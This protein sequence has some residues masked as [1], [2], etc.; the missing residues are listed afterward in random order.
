MTD[1][2]PYSAA[3]HHPLAPFVLD[4]SLVRLEPLSLDH[5]DGLAGAAGRDR[6][7][8]D[9]TP[10]PDGVAA[11]RAYV[12]GLLDEQHRGVSLPF[13]Q[14]QLA[15]GEVVGS[16]RLFDMHWWR[17]R[18]HPDE[19]EIGGTWLARSAQRTGLNRDAK[20]LLLTHAFEVWGVG[21]VQLCTDARNDRSR[22]AIVGIGASFEGILRNHRLRSD[23]PILRDTAVYSITDQEWPDV[24]ILL[25][26]EP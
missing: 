4:G 19:V 26:G 16:T 17:G 12:A 2:A 20:L 14:R 3:M 11:M 1:L 8:F 23:A 10:V 18:E 13:A 25:T 6:S 22:S 9:L 24:R 5:V 7:T 15:T 21:R